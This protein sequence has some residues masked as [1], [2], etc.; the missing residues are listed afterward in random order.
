LG[1]NPT[2]LS[3]HLAPRASRHGGTTLVG[4]GTHGD[5][6]ADGRDIGAAVRAANI[7]LPPL[8]AGGHQADVVHRKIR[9]GIRRRV[10]PV[11]IEVRTHPHPRPLNNRMKDE[12]R[13]CRLFA[14]RPAT[15]LI[16]KPSF[17]N[18]NVFLA[19][20]GCF[21]ARFHSLRHETTAET[22]RAG[23]FSQL[24]GWFSRPCR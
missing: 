21:E 9:R 16:D 10:A 7:D 24:T 22:A 14:P 19:S 6:V 17:I 20:N 4:N 5:G 12:A 2:R 15:A 1:Q 3:Y 18:T 8:R 13:S 23:I 11:R